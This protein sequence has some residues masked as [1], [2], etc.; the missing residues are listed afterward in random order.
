MLCTTT[1]PPSQANRNSSVSSGLA[2]SLPEALSVK[3]GPRPGLQAGAFRSGPVYLH[4]RTRSVVRHYSSTSTR[5]VE[6]QAR[7]RKKSRPVFAICQ[8]K[9]CAIQTKLTNS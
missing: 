1:V 8:I 4:A 3:T 9:V 5:Q 6:F 2:V 7:P